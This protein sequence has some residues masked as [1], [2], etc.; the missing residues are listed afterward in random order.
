MNACHRLG[1][2]EAAQ[3]MV[4]GELD[5]AELVRGC[6]A[7]IAELEPTVEA[8]AWMDPSRALRCA[9]AA[10][11]MWRERGAPGPLH[12][13]PFGVKDILPVRGLPC[14]RGSAVFE[15]HVAE[16][17]ARVVERLEQAGAFVLGKTVTAELAYLTPGR[18]RNP[19]NP[20]HTPG[21]SSS[22]SAAAVAAGFCPGALGTQ[23]N[24]SVIRPASFCGV[25]GYKPTQGA[26]SAEGVHPFSRTLDQI[27]VFARSVADAAWLASALAEDEGTIPR[28]P[29]L[30]DHPP[31]LASVRTPVWHQ[32][33]AAQRTRFAEDLHTLRRAGASVEDAELPPRFDHAHLA[34]RRIMLR[35]GA[36][37]LAPLLRTRAHALSAGLRAA[38]AEGAQVSDAELA[39]ARAIRTELTGVLDDFL[40]D[41]DAIATPPTVGEAPWGLETT[42]DPAFCTI[43]SLTGVP[44]IVIPSGLGPAQL[45][46]G[47]QLTGRRGR[48]AATLAAAAWCEAQLRFQL[49]R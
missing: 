42:G 14:E 47:L 30:P 10:D 23:T 35:E 48:D 45:P 15:G 29:A 31:T 8:F 34:L 32:A 18:T 13:L 46:L 22:G 17:S 4:R 27:G 20:A 44:A 16:A 25:V 11:A 38:L 43:W 36:D 26:I 41:V 19:W 24:G 9:E 40:G 1:L 12:G 28:I 3:R 37:E 49:A 33:T 21:G 2:V 6:L 39:E 5:S 7:R